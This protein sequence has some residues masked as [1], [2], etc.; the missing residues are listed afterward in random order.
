MVANTTS[1][2]HL[3]QNLLQKNPMLGV[4]ILIEFFFH[5]QW[6]KSLPDE[7]VSIQTVN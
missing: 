4:K 2:S 5:F 7:F 3:N 1:V 6:P